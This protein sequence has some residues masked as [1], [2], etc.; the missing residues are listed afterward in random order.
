[1]RLP[2]GGQ[3]SITRLLRLCARARA[4]I[5]GAGVCDF[6]PAAPAVTVLVVLL[7]GPSSFTVR[8]AFAAAAAAAATPPAATRVLL[9]CS[10]SRLGWPFDQ[11]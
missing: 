6:S 1:M 10:V 9:C 7:D 4:A 3:A 5:R 11:G 8:L 2:L